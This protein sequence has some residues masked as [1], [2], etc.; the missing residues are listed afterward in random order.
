M[1][2]SNKSLVFMLVISIVISV[3]GAIASFNKL[4][5][6]E[7]L[8][9]FTGFWSANQTTTYGAV[10]ITIIANLAINFSDD[11]ADFGSGYILSGYDSCTIATDGTNNNQCTGF[12]NATGLILENIGTVNARINISNENYTNSLLG[13]TKS[14]YAWKWETP[15]SETDK[16]VTCY[17]ATEAGLNATVAAAYGEYQNITQIFSIPTAFCDKFNYSN[18]NDIINISIKFHIDVTTLARTVSD[19]WLVTAISNP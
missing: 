5:G 10:N 4:S 2:L 16:T 3:F 7:D 11:T 12:T 13:G 9:S 15:E 14:G 19:T 17:N 18:D 8:F 6:N 1:A